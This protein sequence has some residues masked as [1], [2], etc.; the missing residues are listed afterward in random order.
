MDFLDVVYWSVCVVLVG[1]G[2]GKWVAPMPFEQATSDLGLPTFA[3][4]GRVVGTFEVV[5]GLLG[6]LTASAVVAAAVGVLFVVFSVVVAA[7]VQ[8]G[9]EDCGCIGVTSS[10]PGWIHAV[11]NSLSAMACFAT[12][13][14]GPTAIGTGLASASW[15]VSVAAGFAVALLAG[16]V[17]AVFATGSS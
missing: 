17:L 4:M 7:A 1:S 6:V 12:A 9:L 8:A 16:I 2:V 3:G 14:V 11:L 13:A 10:R 15:P 5:L